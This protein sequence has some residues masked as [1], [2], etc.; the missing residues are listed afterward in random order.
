MDDL[1]GGRDGGLHLVV[2]LQEYGAHI[3]QTILSMVVLHPFKETGFQTLQQEVYRGASQRLA[4]TFELQ[5]WTKKNEAAHHQTRSNK[6]PGIL[7][8]SR[9]AGLSM[10]NMIEQNH[11]VRAGKRVANGIHQMQYVPQLSTIEKT[12]GGSCFA[13]GI[14]GHGQYQTLAKKNLKGVQLPLCQLMLCNIHCHSP[15][16]SKKINGCSF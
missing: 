16:K 4:C 8:S 3:G 13:S 6:Q 7:L 11:C 2:F 12:A 14:A 10:P 15:K 5:K 1:A 9:Q